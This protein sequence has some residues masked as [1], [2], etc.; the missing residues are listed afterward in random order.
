MHPPQNHW[1]AHPSAPSQYRTESVLQDAGPAPAWHWV[2]F[3]LTPVV[4]VLPLVSGWAFP[5]LK[6]AAALLSPLLAV[7]SLLASAGI[8]I[9]V[10]AAR[11]SRLSAQWVRHVQQ[12]RLAT[13]HPW[14][15]APPPP[16]PRIPA[17]DL[18]PR[19]LWYVFAALCLPLS[20]PVALV[21]ALLLG[22]VVGGSPLSLALPF[23]SLVALGVALMVGLRRT[24]HR[25]RLVREYMAREWEQVLR[26]RPGTPGAQGTPTA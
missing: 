14:Y 24:G 15:Q 4:L 1:S 17:A 7:L 11:T 5:S 3:L 6:H 13:G 22:E 19:R 26:D 16:Q 18:R 23:G 25:G 9:G 21:I 8:L 2:G 12:L 10:H 20:I